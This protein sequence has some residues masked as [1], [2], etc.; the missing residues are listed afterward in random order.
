M[1]QQSTDYEANQGLVSRI[2]GQR[3]AF[4]HDGALPYVRALRTYDPEKGVR[5]G[6]WY[7]VNLKL[8][9][10]ERTELTVRKKSPPPEDRFVEFGE[11]TATRDQRRLTSGSPNPEE[12]CE[13][14]DGLSKLSDDARFVV[15]KVLGDQDEGDGPAKKRTKWSGDGPVG[16]PRA[17]RRELREWLIGL[18]WC[19]FRV[20]K[21][22]R[23]IKGFLKT[24]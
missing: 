6:T 1:L 4:E 24:T 12:L 18:G 16:C 15:A 19:P 9:K 11:V 8:A 21:A 10:R 20:T 23:E 3:A 13:F 7:G 14:R 22:F 5:F 17:V 2:L